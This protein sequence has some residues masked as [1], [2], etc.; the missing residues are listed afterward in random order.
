MSALFSRSP[1]NEADDRMACMVPCGPPWLG[2]AIETFG[3][4]RAVPGC[5]RAC[6]T[7]EGLSGMTTFR[8]GFLAELDAV[9]AG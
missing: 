5:C 9:V 7:P 3:V 2:V 8:P 6:P 1:E 4:S